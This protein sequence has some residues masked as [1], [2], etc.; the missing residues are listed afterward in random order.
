MFLCHCKNTINISNLKI[1]T[2]NE[3]L[4]KYLSSLSPTERIAK[5]RDI[6]T[7]CRKSPSVLCYWRRGRTKIDLAWRDKI[8][9]AIGENIF[10]NVTD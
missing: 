4:D 8:S 5:S 2:A 3:A 6:R 7:I 9:E 10:A 1:M